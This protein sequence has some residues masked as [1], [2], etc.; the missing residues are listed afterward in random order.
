MYIKISDLEV[1]FLLVNIAP[2]VAPRS[3]NE[4]YYG[5]LRGEKRRAGMPGYDIST[6]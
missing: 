5:F 1:L 3:Q 6:D 2:M 4:I